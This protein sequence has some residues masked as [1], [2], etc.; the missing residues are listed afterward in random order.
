VVLAFRKIAA[1]NGPDAEPRKYESKRRHRLSRRETRD[2]RTGVDDGC[3]EEEEE[4]C[5]EEGE[6]QEQEALSASFA[7]LLGSA[8][9]LCA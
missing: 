3:Q 8:R 7:L 9:K 4:G 1:R 2:L 5:E 6:A